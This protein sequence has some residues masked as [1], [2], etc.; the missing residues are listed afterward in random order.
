[1]ARAHRLLSL[2]A[3][4]HLSDIHSSR[5]MEFPSKAVLIKNA[6]MY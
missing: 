4:Q 3:D 6:F 5:R 1:M 2:H